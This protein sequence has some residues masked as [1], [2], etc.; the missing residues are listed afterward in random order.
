[1]DNINIVT[2]TLYTWLSQDVVTD[3]TLY[4][5]HL[6]ITNGVMDNINIVTNKL[7]IWL[8]HNVVMDNINIVTYTLYILVIPRCCDR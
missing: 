7:Y 6:I 2:Y 3:N 8:S 4:I 1:M 5:I